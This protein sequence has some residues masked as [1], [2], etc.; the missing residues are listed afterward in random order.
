MAG[1]SGDPNNGAYSIVIS[2]QYGEFDVD[3]GGLVRYSA[4]GAKESRSKEPDSEKPGVKALKRSIET[5]EPVRVLRNHTCSWKDRPARGIRYDGLYRVT[6]ANVETNAE[7]GK[8]WRFTLKRL[9]NQD[10]INTSM[11]TKEMMNLFEKVSEGY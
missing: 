10:P 7:E 11:P 2:Q 1:I 8:F 4:P 9:N 5:K 6:E 3:E